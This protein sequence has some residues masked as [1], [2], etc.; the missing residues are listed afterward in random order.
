MEGDTSKEVNPAA[1]HLESRRIG[2]IFHQLRRLSHDHWSLL[3][4]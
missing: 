4:S 3:A 1:V 2:R